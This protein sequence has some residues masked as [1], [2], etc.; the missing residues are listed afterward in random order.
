MEDLGFRKVAR[1]VFHDVSYDLVMSGA[2][3]SLS[4]EVEHTDDGRKWRS[5]WTADFIEGITQRTGNAKKFDVFVKMLCSALV[6]ESDAVYLDVLT[7][8]DVA[9]LR[10]H[11]NPQTATPQEPPATTGAVAQSDKR[12]LIL[13]YRAEFDKIH[14]PL[15]LA[16]EERSE[17]DTLKALVSRLQGELA[18]ARRAIVSYEQRGVT[19]EQD[20]RTG[21]LERENSELHEALRASRW[22]ID[23]LKGELRLRSVPAGGASAGSGANSEAAEIRKLRDS[24]AR[25]Q[26]EIKALKDELRQRQAA[27]KKEIDRLSSDMKIERTRSEKAQMHIRKV[28]QDQK[29]MSVR[30]QNAS[31][32]PSPERSRPTSRSP[33]CDR[34]RPPSRP[35]SRPPSRQP[36]RPTSRPASRSSSVASSRERSPSP[37]S[38]LGREG[39][40]QGSSASRPSGQSRPW[41]FQRENSPSRA[42]EK[43]NIS[44]YTRNGGVPPQRRTPSPG[45]RSAARERTPSPV[46]AARSALSLREGGPPP[47]SSA[48]RSLPAPSGMY[49]ASSASSVRGSKPASTRYAP[50]NSRPG[51]A[52]HDGAGRDRLSSVNTLEGA[53]DRAFSGAPSSRP[54]SRPVSRGPPGHREASDTSIATPGSLFGLAANLGLGL[55]AQSSCPTASSH[56]DSEPCDIHA[57]LGALTAFLRQTKTTLE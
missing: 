37:S 10:R 12:Y 5:T 17:A 56:V 19:S 44:P 3:D 31:R 51:S 47:R 6:Q 30:L 53:H 49:P 50:P 34:G 1:R 13:T 9:M 54:G 24:S 27:Y 11:A 38:F 21:L 7:A 14:Y 23:Q 15:P 36:S 42:N 55:N 8:R 16:L 26:A 32:G 48:P 43:A 4:I 45:A 18:D 35:A 40:R 29:N 33:S 41:A 25:Q 46:T 2:P 28:E 52:S 22:D 57:R 20:E 39:G